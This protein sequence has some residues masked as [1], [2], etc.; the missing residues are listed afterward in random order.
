LERIA[1]HLRASLSLDLRGRR[2]PALAAHGQ[3]LV[4][5]HHQSRIGPRAR[6]QRR[7]RG[8]HERP[9]LL[10]WNHEPK[11]AVDAPEREQPRAANR[12]RHV[13]VHRRCRV[14]AGRP[15]G[16]Y[17]GK[18]RPGTVRRKEPAVDRHQGQRHSVRDCLAERASPR[19]LVDRMR[20][21]WARELHGHPRPALA[22]PAQRRAIQRRERSDCLGAGPKRGGWS[23]RRRPLLRLL[24]L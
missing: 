19:E 7:R 21:G 14:R 10:P 16:R 4:R 8:G 3:R 6:R 22:V 20:S 2:R 11:P 24:C 1:L 23:G 13:R 15:R 17:D 5:E 18:H 12:R 9:Q